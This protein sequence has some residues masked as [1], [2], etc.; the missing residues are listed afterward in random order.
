MMVPQTPSAPGLSSRENA[1][2]MTVVDISQVEIQPSC[3]KELCEF[4]GTDAQFKS[5]YQACAF[6]LFVWCTS[7][8]LVVLD[9]GGRK[10]LLYMACTINASEQDCVTVVIVPLVSLLSDLKTHLRAAKICMI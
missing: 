3:L 2:G 4:M 9:A 7:D 5:S 10:L 8:L 1:L 6:E